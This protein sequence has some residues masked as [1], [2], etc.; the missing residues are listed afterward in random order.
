MFDSKRIMAAVAR[1]FNFF[2]NSYRAFL[3]LR[4]P[5]RQLNIVAP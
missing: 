4:M 5:N 1:D 3:H 2:E